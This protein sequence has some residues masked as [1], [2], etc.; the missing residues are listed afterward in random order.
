MDAPERPAPE[1]EQ[2]LLDKARLLH[3]GGKSGM[4]MVKFDGRTV[5]F[6]RVLPDGRVE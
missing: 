3:N 5:T 1:W 6:W 2:R 4:L